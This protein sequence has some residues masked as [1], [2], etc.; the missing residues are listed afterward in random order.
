MVESR[1]GN[2]GGGGCWRV[3]SGIPHNKTGG[4]FMAMAVGSP[5]K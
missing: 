4:C 5:G 2:G 1:V 3:I